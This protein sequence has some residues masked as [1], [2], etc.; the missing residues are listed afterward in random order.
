ML[1]MSLFL[2]SVVYLLFQQILEWFPSKSK[3]IIMLAYQMHFI[4]I[5]LA[6]YHRTRDH[7]QK[8]RCW[9]NNCCLWKLSWII[10]ILHII[11]IIKILFINSFPFFTIAF[12]RDLDPLTWQM[13]HQDQKSSSSSD[14][15]DA[16]Q[17]RD[18]I[19]TLALGP[20][21]KLGLG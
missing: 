20:K 4:A 10:I 9:Y 12:S 11:K 19:V 16:I 14:Y 18:I 5:T 17:C 7:L 3:C 21:E 2:F 15:D 8:L 1:L 13:V 6:Q